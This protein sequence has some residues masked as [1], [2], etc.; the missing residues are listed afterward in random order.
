MNYEY[1]EDESVDSFDSDFKNTDVGDIYIDPQELKGDYLPK[2]RT[3]HELTIVPEEIIMKKAAA[4][5]QRLETIAA[6]LDMELK[7]KTEEEKLFELLEQ[8]GLSKPDLDGTA[9]Y[10]KSSLVPESTLRF[11][12]KAAIRLKYF[13]STGESFTHYSATYWKKF[14]K[15]RIMQLHT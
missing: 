1:N 4:P 10:K 13:L 9:F 5:N 3:R 8:L 11:Y 15:D 6:N 12:I 7:G 2:L 14:P